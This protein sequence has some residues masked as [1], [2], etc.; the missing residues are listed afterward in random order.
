[1][2]GLMRMDKTT[3]D[4][5][6]VRFSDR[7]EWR[8]WLEKNH[9]DEA[10]VWLVIKKKGASLKAVS[11]EEAVEEALCFGW[12][13]GKMHSVDDQHYVLRF[14]PRKPRSIWSQSNRERVERL[15]RLGKMTEAGL[16]KVEEAKQNGRWAAA[17]TSK[18]KPAMPEDLQAALAQDVEAQANF[19]GFAPS[20]QTMYVAWIEQAKR[21]ETRQRRIQEVVKRSRAK[22]KPGI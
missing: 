7:D 6:S 13:D 2:Q 1:V 11:Y 8:R 3:S 15:M 10:E 4:V 22:I 18:E 14:S 20:A 21:V 12:I 16:A 9:A 5:T 17:Y 19:Y